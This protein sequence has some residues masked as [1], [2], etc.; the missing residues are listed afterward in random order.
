M[1]EELIKCICGDCGHSIPLSMKQSRDIKADLQP[2]PLTCQDCRLLQ[3][4]LVREL[5]D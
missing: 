2:A 4:R 5:E 1:T 3:D